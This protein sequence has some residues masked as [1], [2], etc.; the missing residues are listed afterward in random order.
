MITWSIL[1]LVAWLINIRRIVK[2]A[3]DFVIL[4]KLA[5]SIYHAVAFGLHLVGGGFSLAA[6]AYSYFY[7]W[8][9]SHD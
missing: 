9:K 2:F 8:S 4:T 3:R 6:V 5:L 7:K 1:G